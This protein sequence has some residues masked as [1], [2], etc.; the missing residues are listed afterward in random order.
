MSYYVFFY[1]YIAAKDYKIVKY[2]TY[3]F[4]SKL[5]NEKTT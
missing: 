5:Q 1:F 4:I 3:V 2:S